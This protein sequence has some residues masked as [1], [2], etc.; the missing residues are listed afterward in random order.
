MAPIARDDQPQIGT[1]VVSQ[2]I[3]AACTLSSSAARFAFD[4]SRVKADD[5]GWLDAVAGCFS[6]GALRGRTLKVVGHADPR[7][8]YDYNQTLGQRRADSISNYLQGH[9]LAQVFIRSSSRGAVDAIGADEMSWAR[10]RRVDL[11]IAL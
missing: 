3:L 1:I 10:D 11:T 2:E 6:S 9:G 4:S 5:D 8:T 7:G